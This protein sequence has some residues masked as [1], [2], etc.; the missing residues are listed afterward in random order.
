MYQGVRLKP[1]NAVPHSSTGVLLGAAVVEVPLKDIGEDGVLLINNVAGATD[2]LIEFWDDPLDSNSMRIPAYSSMIVTVPKR[3][4]KAV[5][6]R[7]KRPTG[8][9]TDSVYITQG[10]GF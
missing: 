3:A 1:F 9:A 5:F 8:S 7:L 6:V 4:S 10:F 2:V